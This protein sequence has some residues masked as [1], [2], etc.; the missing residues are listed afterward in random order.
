MSLL[1][2]SAKL[3]RF[4][5]APRLAP[6]LR[7]LKNF[8]VNYYRLYSL[9]LRKFLLRNYA[10]LSRH[11]AVCRS[12]FFKQSKLSFVFFFIKIFFKR[13]LKLFSNFVVFNKHSFWVS[14][15]FSAFVPEF[16]Y[17]SAA[18]TLLAGGPSAD[19]AA[20]YGL[21]RGVLENL[22]S[23][24][25]ATFADRDLAAKNWMPLLTLTNF[26]ARFLTVPVEADLIFLRTFD[27]RDLLRV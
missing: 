7:A 22:E 20:I 15:S 16:V 13:S 24:S 9:L 2:K 27:S 1:Q 21:W 17:A 8:R 18:K 12:N 19:G 6:L 3:V 5:F 25:I 10:L 23:S 26:V 14:V 11:K 4:S